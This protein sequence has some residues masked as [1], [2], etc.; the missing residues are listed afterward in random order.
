MNVPAR[1]ALLLVLAVVAAFVGGW[2]CF[3]TASWYRSFP[4][5]GLHW[6]PVLGPYNEHLAKD[7]GAMYLALAVLGLTAAR[8]AAGTRLAQAA[9]LTWLVFSVPHFAYHMR[10]LDMYG[11]RDKALNVVTLGLFV[12]AGAALLLPAR[13]PRTP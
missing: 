12:L 9:G 2:A 11:A 7:V 6:L 13:E 5:L 1:R 4:G 8:R 3:A 10:H